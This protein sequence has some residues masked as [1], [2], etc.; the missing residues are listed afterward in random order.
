[1]ERLATTISIIALLVSIVSA[2]ES[3]PSS[4]DI[5]K[6]EAIRQSY[7]TFEELTRL[8]LENWQLSHMFA[9]PDKYDEV[10]KQVT[11]SSGVIDPAKPILQG[12]R[13]K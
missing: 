12:Q 8:Q 11:S 3:C 6:S 2:Y 10:V 9:L 13:R 1:M 7:T 5:A 4:K